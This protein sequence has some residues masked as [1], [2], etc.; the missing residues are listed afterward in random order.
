MRELRAEG[1]DLGGL[2]EGVNGAA[3]DGGFAD[4][5][6]LAQCGEDGGGVGGFDLYARG[7]GGIG[8]GK[9]LEFADGAES[10]KLGHVDVA[11]AAATLG[12]VHVM[13]GDEEGDSLAG[14]E[15][16]EV[17]EGAAGDG[18]DAGGGLVEEDDFGRVDDGAAEGEAL[19]PAAGEGADAA[20]EVGLEAGEGEDLLFA[21]RARGG[22]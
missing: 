14:E 4:A 12:L 8:F 2:D 19:F 15:E 21:L 7:A 22:R 1:V 11:D 5:G 17:P 18:I 13:G 6:L 16:E 20:M 9:M 10:D 3:E